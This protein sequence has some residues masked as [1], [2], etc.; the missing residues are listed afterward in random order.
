MNTDAEIGTASR[1][2]PD[3]AYETKR[4]SLGEQALPSETH[5]PL[6]TRQRLQHR[7]GLARSIGAVYYGSVNEGE[8]SEPTTFSG[9]LISAFRRLGARLVKSRGLPDYP[10][11]TLDELSKLKLDV[12]SGRRFDLRFR[13]VALAIIALMLGGGAAGTLQEFGAIGTG[14]WALLFLACLFL[15]FPIFF[16]THHFLTRSRP[17]SLQSG[18]EMSLFIIQEQ[19]ARGYYEIAYV[20]RESGTYF[21]RVYGEP[22]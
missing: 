22:N 13:W 20:D 18:Q 16:V 2:S 7:F 5:Q 4:G 21:R 1:R 3:R 15:C 12:E 9:R 6:V 8:S 19:E 11:I 17:R 10:R 14:V